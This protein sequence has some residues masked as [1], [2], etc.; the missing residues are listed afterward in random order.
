MTP[1]F[2]AGTAAVTQDV[3]HP[4]LRSISASLNIVVQNLLG[5]SLGPL[6]VGAISDHYP[7]PLVG[8]LT[9]FKFLP[10][11]SLFGAACF[12]LGSFFYVRDL[13]KVER[14]AIE[15]ER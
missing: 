7:D 11:F 9:G 10:I 12:L 2:V 14:V 15:P 13:A 3:V 6:F 1:M 5:A 8:L 4:G